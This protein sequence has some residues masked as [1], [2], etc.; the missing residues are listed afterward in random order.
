MKNLF[1]PCLVLLLLM[2][3]SVFPSQGNSDPPN[4]PP[5]GIPDIPLTVT[6]E[7]FTSRI[8]NYIA[9][10][11]GFILFLFVAG[12]FKDNLVLNLICLTGIFA[13][14][15]TAVFYARIGYLQPGLPEKVVFTAG[16]DIGMAHALVSTS[17]LFFLAYGLYMLIWV[18]GNTLSFLIGLISGGI[19]LLFKTD[20]NKASNFALGCL[21]NLFAITLIGGI[22]FCYYLLLIRTSYLQMFLFGNYDPSLGWNLPTSFAF[23]LLAN[24]LQLQ[25]EAIK[26]DPVLGLYVLPL[27][28]FLTVAVK[29]G[30]FLEAVQKIRNFFG[31][32]RETV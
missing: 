25:W 16:F 2:G 21:G 23:R 6:T 29:I 10:F 14:L 4:T 20:T 30:G 17:I 11:F 26:N 24:Q 7:L 1:I 22:P 12:I 8:I 32:E 31:K 13:V 27:G 15:A 9:L 5:A 28:A 18:I 19:D 3:C